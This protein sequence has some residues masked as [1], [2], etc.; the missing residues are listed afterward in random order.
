MASLE[1]QVAVITGAS[2]GIGAATARNL[3]AAGIKLVLN[4]RR[5]DRLNEL[6]SEIPGDAAV[7][8]ADILDPALPQK[9]ID[10]A[11]EIFGRCD[12]VFNNAGVLHIDPID[13]IDIEAVCMMVRI[14]VE[15]VYRLVH[16]AV[17]HFRKPKDQGGGG[18]SGHL[19]NTSSILGTKVR[20][21]AGWYAGTKF[22]IEALSEALRMELAG[23]DIRISC[24]EPGLVA[25]E[26]HREW[27]TPPADVLGIE[28]PLVPDDVARLVRFVLEQPAHVRLPRMMILPG[29]HEI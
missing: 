5:E 20:P 21:T 29:E 2:S 15:A 26:L 17:M 18:N 23:T 3:S 22:P 11:T 13:K 24:I 14:N 7:V 12:I 28:K 10:T 16:T 8:A 25:T 1:G 6:A 9:L 4:A 27:E 19:I